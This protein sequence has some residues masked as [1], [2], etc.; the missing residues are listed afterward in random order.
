MNSPAQT[1]ALE[2]WYT[3]DPDQ[4]A[5]LGSCCTECNT[6][7]FPKMTRFCRN[8]NCQSES[9][10][11]VELSRTGTVWSY[12]DARYQPP[13]PFV[14]ADPFE[15]FAIIGVYLEREKMVVLGQAAR[16][17]TVDDLKVGMP[18][19]LVLDTLYSDDEGDKMVWKWQPEGGKAD[20]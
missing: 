8:P 20:E 14:S 12:T 11:E 3:L 6:Y 18:V 7:Y 5:L 19:E 13:E 9:F 2:G 1:A 4:P 17:V 15:P 16:G 10:D